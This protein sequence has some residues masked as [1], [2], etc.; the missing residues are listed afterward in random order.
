[1]TSIAYSAVTIQTSSES[2]PS[3]R[4]SVWGITPNKKPHF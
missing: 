4:L 2:V 3:T 1:M